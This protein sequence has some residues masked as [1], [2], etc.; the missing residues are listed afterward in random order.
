[1]Q[2]SILGCG[3]LGLPLANSLITDGY[4]V[5]GSTTTEEKVET[6]RR[7]GIEP[8]IISLTQTGPV[9]NIRA[10]LKDSEVLIIDIPPKAR[11]GESYPDKIKNL[12]PHIKNAGIEK[13]LFVSSTSVYADDNSIVTEGTTPNPDSESGKHVFEAEQLLR[14]ALPETTVLRFAGL[15]GE[16]RHPVYHLAGRK[17]VANPEAPVNLIHRND[18]TGIIKA[19]ILKNAWSEVFNAASPEHPTRKDYYT[20]KAIELGLELPEFEEGKESV[21]KTITSERLTTILGYEFISAI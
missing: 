5:K 10:F 11:S 21:G 2:I 1:M 14:E 6:L 20:R 9:G 12:I 3:W 8:Y 18:C 7:A 13:V 16:D 15:I 4:T 17:G 19:I